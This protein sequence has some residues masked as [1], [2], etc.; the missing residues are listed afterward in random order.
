MKPRG[1]KEAE[2]ARRFMFL[3]STDTEIAEVVGEV[4]GMFGHDWSKGL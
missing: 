4:L 2:K 3:A 1:H